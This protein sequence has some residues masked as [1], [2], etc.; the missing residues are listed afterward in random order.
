MILVIIRN[1]VTIAIETLDTDHGG[2]HDVVNNTGDVVLADDITEGGLP[3]PNGRRIRHNKRPEV[4]ISPDDVEIGSAEQDEVT[5]EIARHTLA[6]VEIS[7]YHDDIER[8][9]G[10]L[11]DGQQTALYEAALKTAAICEYT[12][13]IGAIRRATPARTTLCDQKSTLHNERRKILCGAFPNYAAE[14]NEGFTLLWYLEKNVLP[15]YYSMI[16]QKFL[17][18]DHDGDLNLT[19]DNTDKGIAW[20]S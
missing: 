2:I 3:M 9:F 13:K 4:P 14:D 18:N 1:I 5:L 10:S 15:K 8:F 17:R 19:R 16:I 6:A 7:A 12:I 11:T 20:R